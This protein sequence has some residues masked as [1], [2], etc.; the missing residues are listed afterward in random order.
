MAGIKSLLYV[1]SPRP[2]YEK[3]AGPIYPS[4]ISRNIGLSQQSRADVVVS[5]S[6]ILEEWIRPG[7]CWS[8]DESVIG[9]D[10]WAGFVDQESL[11]FRANDIS[12]PL[13][14]P[15]EALLSIEV[16]VRLPIPTTRGFAVQKVLELSQELNIG[17]FPGI[18]GKNL[19]ITSCRAAVP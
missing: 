14:G 15:K 2:P 6:D 18:P 17:L 16:A 7:M 10:L 9:E 8:L 19:G 5:A 13:V 4:S 11:S 1:H 3:I 12:L